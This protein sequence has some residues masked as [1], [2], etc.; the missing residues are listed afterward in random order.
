MAIPG[1]TINHH[2]SGSVLPIFNIE[3][4]V[5]VSAGTPIFK[6]DSPLSIKMAEAIPNAMV[7]K[8]GAIELGKACLKII[9][10]GLK[11]IDRAAVIYSI[12]RTRNISERVNLAISVHDVNPIITIT[13]HKL[14]S[15]MMAENEI[16]K[17]NFGIEWKISISLEIIESTGREIRVP[18]KPFFNHFT[19][20]TNKKGKMKNKKRL[21]NK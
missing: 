14:R 6:N 3:P 15:S 18:K 10:Q 21:N 11:P 16:I 13:N 1:N 9:R 12:S 20:I 7:T 17:S 5:T 19:E 2:A 4:Q 8:T